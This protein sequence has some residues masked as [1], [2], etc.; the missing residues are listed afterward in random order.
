MTILIDQLLSQLNTEEDLGLVGKI[1]D[2]AQ[3]ENQILAETDWT[4]E[5]WRRYLARYL[6]LKFLP[7]YHQAPRKVASEGL[8]RK[9]GLYADQDANQDWFALLGDLRALHRWSE[10][11]QAIGGKTRPVISLKEPV[12]NLVRL[13]QLSEQKERG[14][15]IKQLI[16]QLGASPTFDQGL[17]LMKVI[18]DYA[19]AD[20]ASFINLTETAHH[21]IINF[22]VRH[23]LIDFCVLPKS[24]ADL[25][26][27]TALSFPG[28]VTLPSDINKTVTL[29]VTFESGYSA[30]KVISERGLGKFLERLHRGGIMFVLAGDFRAA[31]D[32]CYDLLGTVAGPQYK[33]IVV[34]EK[35]SAINP[36]S[37]YLSIRPKMGLNLD[38]VFKQAISLDPDLVLLGQLETVDSLMSAI[39]LSLLGRSVLIPVEAAGFPELAAKLENFN[40]P[41]TKFSS[42]VSGLIFVTDEGIVIDDPASLFVTEK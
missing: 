15:Q 5:T 32:A 28:A 31:K 38:L 18:V 13:S 35:P 42:Y 19:K 41:L 24:V 27:Q 36:Y 26:L 6:G 22:R 20:R 1:T 37:A 9:Y 12:V 39:S 34:D 7:A 4:E 8:M 3:L 30:P 2:L 33:T 16:N 11:E 25:L 29:P 21:L 40:F 14:G 10:I 17:E 23:S